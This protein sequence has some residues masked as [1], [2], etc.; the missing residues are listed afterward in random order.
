[1]YTPR[2]SKLPFTSHVFIFACRVVNISHM[3]LYQSWYTKFLAALTSNRLEVLHEQNLYSLLQL[4]ATAIPMHV[5]CH[6]AFH[7]PN[8][9]ISCPGKGPRQVPNWHIVNWNR[10]QTLAVIKPETPLQNILVGNFNVI[11][12]G[13]LAT[14]S[15]YYFR[16]R[17]KDRNILG[18]YNCRYSSI[19]TLDILNSFVEYRNDIQ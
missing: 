15:I 5:K 7:I 3:L 6:Q 9:R 12:G 18:V 13:S 1:M 11:Q 16:K 17:C 8:Q 10:K 19:K 2:V 14:S 4:L